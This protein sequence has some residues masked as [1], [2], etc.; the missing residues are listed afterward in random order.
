MKGK[1]FITILALTLGITSCKNKGTS[2]TNLNPTTETTIK[3]DKNMNSFISIF[4][5][6]ATDISRAINFYREILGVE[7]EK[8]EFPGMELGLFPYQDQMV[9]GVIMKGEGYEPSAS[10]VTIYLNGGENLQTILDKVEGNGGKIIIPKTPHADEIG[11]FAI[12]H[13]SEGNKI[14]LHSPN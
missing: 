6:P 13:D 14:G 3:N 7:I 11:F 2:S 1:I 9:T 8:M 10:G 5:I 12:F 4:E